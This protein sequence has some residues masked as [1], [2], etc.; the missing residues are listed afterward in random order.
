VTPSPAGERRGSTIRVELG[1]RSYE[2]HVRPGLLA[3]IGETLAG[4]AKRA[5]IVSDDRV[6]ALYLNPVRASL[7]RA[8][9]AVGQATVPPGEESKSL[10][11]LAGLL[12]R[13]CELEIERRDL[14]IALGGGVVGD[15]AGLAA[16]LFRRGIPLAQLPTSLM[17]QVDSAIGGKTAVNLAAGKNLA[18][19]FHQPVAVLCDPEVLRTLPDSEFRSGLAEVVKYGILG[20]AELFELLEQAG[21]R[22]LHRDADLLER[23]IR[24]C[25]AAKAR[26]VS[27]DERE[28][29]QER[30]LL[31]LGHTLGHALEAHGSYGSYRHGE[32]VAIG[33]A[34]A[35]RASAGEG[36]LSGPQ[37]KR[38]V[39]LLRELGLPTELPNVDAGELL[40]PIRQDKKRAG[41]RIR[42]VLP[43]SVGRCL[44]EP[45]DIDRIGRWIERTREANRTA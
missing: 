28:T 25:V 26:I 20:D 43:V 29:G 44:V 11:R 31:N 14:V 27:A 18:G 1:T 30:I 22:I 24:H 41:D 17:A 5:V 7:E 3:E 16:S 19:T 13:F 38:I 36:R 15:L 37:M 32:A 23:V 21:G 8:G 10:A 12:D 6:A 42:F 2:V 39:G 40:A 35:A 4:E 33:I 34:F 9:L 45:V